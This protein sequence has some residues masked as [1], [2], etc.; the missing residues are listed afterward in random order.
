[1]EGLYGR[2]HKGREK[3]TAGQVKVSVCGA[4][5]PYRCAYNNNRKELNTGAKGARV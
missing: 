5:R 3:G 1:M 2:E 4:Y